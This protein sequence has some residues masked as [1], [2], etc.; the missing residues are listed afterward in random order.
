M[1]VQTRVLSANEYRMVDIFRIDAFSCSSIRAH[2]MKTKNISRA[3][4]EEKEKR[5]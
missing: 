5:K 3:R 4:E 1:G 2:N